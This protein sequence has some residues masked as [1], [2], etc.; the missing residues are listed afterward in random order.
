MEIEELRNFL[1]VAQEENITRAAEYLHL[2]QPTLSRQMQALEAEFGKQLL[3]RGKRRV[4]LTQDGILFRKRAA[5]II[6]MVDKT[7]AEMRESREDIS[8]DIFIGAGETDVMR[9]VAKAAQELKKQHPGIRF[10]IISG[11]GDAVKEMLN[12]GLI[13][14]GLVFGPADEK[15]YDVIPLGIEDRW[16]VLL[17]RDAPLAQKESI[18]PGDL[19]DKPL[20]LSQ[21]ALTAGFL[22][23]WLKKGAAELHVAATYNLILNAAKM[24]EGGLGCAMVLDGL[25]NTRETDLV[26][27]PCE[28]SLMAGISILSKKYQVF[29]PAAQ[30]FRDM[31][32]GSFAH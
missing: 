31:L 12:K 19:W 26:F 14:F 9:L 5:E 16:G 15:K 20:I 24:V 32:I 8:G 23:T 1:A 30:A 10:R 11:D 7:D 3:I 6:A 18:S 22:E 21:Q 13:D 25:V 29:S 28:P 2:T 27:R 4:T 17:P